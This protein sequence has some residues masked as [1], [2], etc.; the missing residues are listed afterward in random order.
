MILVVADLRRMT[1]RPTLAALTD[2]RRARIYKRASN[3]VLLWSRSGR[4]R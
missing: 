2:Q 1:M 4:G 3:V